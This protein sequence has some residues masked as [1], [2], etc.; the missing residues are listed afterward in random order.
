MVG[1]NGNGQRRWDLNIKVFKVDKTCTFKYNLG[2]E[3]FKL[4]FVV[5][6]SISTGSDDI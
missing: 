4:Y 1:V 5:L 3:Q 2:L 6:A